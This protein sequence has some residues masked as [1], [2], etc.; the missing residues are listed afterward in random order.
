MA[1]AHRSCGVVRA[2]ARVRVS[3][4]VPVRSCVVG[5]HAF[6]LSFMFISSISQPVSQSGSHSPRGPLS[7]HRRKAQ[8]WSCAQHVAAHRPSWQ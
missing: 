1:F 6:I 8:L 3:R 7:P 4:A 2:R 5:Q